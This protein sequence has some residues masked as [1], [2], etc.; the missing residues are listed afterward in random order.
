MEWIVEKMKEKDISLTESE[1]D[2]WSDY[3]KN[4][5]TS[6]TSERGAV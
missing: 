4:E 1:Y 6:G 5:R 2:L 3:H